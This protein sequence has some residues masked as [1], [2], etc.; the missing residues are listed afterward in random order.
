METL[1]FEVV[2]FHGTYHAILGRPCYVK[3]TISTSFQR[4]YECEVECYELASVIIAFEELA[5]IKEATIEEV[6]DSKWSARSFEP[7]EDT[8]E[9]LID[10]SSYEE[11]VVRIDTSL[12]PK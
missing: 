1:T 12:S 5:V 7:T 4:T 9:I 3:F 2:R 10:P 11:K 6:P 8:K